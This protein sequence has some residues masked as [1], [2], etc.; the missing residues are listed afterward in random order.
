MTSRQGVHAMAEGASAVVNQEYVDEARRLSAAHGA[1]LRSSPLANRL[2]TEAAQS[3][4][5]ALDDNHVGT[6]HI[7]LGLFS[8]GRSR[9]LDALHAAGVTRETYL[10]VLDDEA[11]PSPEGPIPYTLRSMMICT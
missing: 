2:M 6:E 7:T 10:S 5:R 1:R 3:E 9:A 4:A 11:G 8:L